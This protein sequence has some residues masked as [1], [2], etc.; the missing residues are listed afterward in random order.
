MKKHLY[1]FEDGSDPYNLN[2]KSFKALSNSAGGEVD[3]NT[4]FEYHEE[5]AKIW[6]RYYGG[7]IQIGS[8]SGFRTSEN[9]IV[10]HYGHWD[11]EGNYKTGKCQSQISLDD[12]TNKLILDEKWEWS[13]NSQK[14]TSKLIEL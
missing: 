6:G 13:H 3:G 14:G 10:F 7:Q 1:I 2:N 4:V 9:T 12:K 5:D 11:E 8:L